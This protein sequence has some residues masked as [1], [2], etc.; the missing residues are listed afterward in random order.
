MVRTFK[1]RYV[2][3]ESVQ[4]YLKNLQRA[5]ACGLDQLPPNLLKDAANE[6]APSL[7]YIINLSLTTSTVPTDRKK[8]KVSPIYKSGSTTEL[9]NYRSI[10]VLSIISKIMEREVHRQLY[11]FLDETKLISKHQFRFEKKKLTELAAIASVHQVR[12]AV[13]NG[14]LVG[15]LYRLTKSFWYH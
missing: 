5:E 10:S 11:E 4:K 9:E 6:I 13:D 15:T 1:F 3:L 12:L 2:S 8:T 14:I 7:T